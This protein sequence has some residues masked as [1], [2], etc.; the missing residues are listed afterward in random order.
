MLISHLIVAVCS[1]SGCPWTIHVIN[2]L[3]PLSVSHFA[4]SKLVALIHLLFGANQFKRE[5]PALSMA[6]QRTMVCEF[7]LI[8]CAINGVI[9]GFKRATRFCLGQ[10]DCSFP[11]QLAYR[12]SSLIS[13]CSVLQNLFLD[14]YYECI[15]VTGFLSTPLINQL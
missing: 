3:C 1:Q 4:S 7:A 10:L 2:F 11:F 15:L 13:L 14:V 8:C 9:S 12:K 5:R 6:N